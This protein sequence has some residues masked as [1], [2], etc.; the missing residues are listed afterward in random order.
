VQVS[1]QVSRAEAQAR[2]RI[3]ADVLDEVIALL[4]EIQKRVKQMVQERGWRGKRT[5]RI[6][7]TRKWFRKI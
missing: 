4:P 6:L 7:G 2:F 5:R 1:L 3:N